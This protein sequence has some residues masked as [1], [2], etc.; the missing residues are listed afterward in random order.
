MKRLS[1]AVM[2]SMFFFAAVGGAA[3][4][5]VTIYG[6][7]Y[8][9]KTKERGEHHK[10]EAHLT[11]TA[12][13]P[14]KGLL[15]VK[16]GGESGKRARVSSAEIDLNG[17]EIAEKRDFKKTASVLEFEVELLATNKM[18]VEV[19]SC[20]ECELEIIVMGEKPAPPPPREIPAAIPVRE[21][22]PDVVTAPVTE[23]APLPVR[24]P[25]L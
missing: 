17:K 6:P 11:F 25:V 3:A 12:P 8:V 18:E 13:V 4:E 9:A 14:G 7:V 19:K 5:L 16:N 20:K 21:P 24:E 10:K 22:V 23:P 2:S 1:I 15:V